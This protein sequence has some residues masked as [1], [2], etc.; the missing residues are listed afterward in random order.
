MEND[1]LKT[2]TGVLHSKLK[3]GKWADHANI[4]S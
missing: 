3:T 2:V 4:L 1:T